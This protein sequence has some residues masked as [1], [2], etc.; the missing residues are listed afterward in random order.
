MVEGKPQ[1]KAVWFFSFELCVCPVFLS[2][3]CFDICLKTFRA[4]LKIIERKLNKLIRLSWIKQEKEQRISFYRKLTGVF[5]S[6]VRKD[7]CAVCAKISEHT[8]DF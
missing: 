1:Y 5:K 2:Y 8:G 3:A 6:M 4:G 7:S